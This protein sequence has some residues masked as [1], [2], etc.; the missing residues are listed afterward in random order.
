M[1]NRTEVYLLSGQ[2][3]NWVFFP[4]HK[5]RRDVIIRPLGLKLLYS[6]EKTKNLVVFEDVSILEKKY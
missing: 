4:A 3:K 5:E 1:S 6:S 2:K